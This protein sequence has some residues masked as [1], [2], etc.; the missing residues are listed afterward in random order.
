M[1]LLAIDTSSIACSVA[2]LA[3]DRVAERHAEIPR[4]HTRILLPMIRELLAEEKLTPAMLDAVVLGNGPGSFIGMRIAASVVQGLAYGAGLSVV[5]VSSLCAVAAEVFAHSEAEEV[6]VAQDAH[7]SE[8]YLGIFGRGPDG[9]PRTLVAEHLHGQGTIADLAD[10]GR[11]AR[12]AAGYG[13]TRYPALWQS[14]RGAIREL[15]DVVHPRA[16]YLLALGQM[17]LENGQAIDPKDINPA[18]LRQEVA[19]KSAPQS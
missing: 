18:Y 8:V 10:A 12:I 4:E 15:S 5:P 14:N 6:I 3:G 17:A 7:M 1:K 9:V 11:A 13:W 19:R 16:S 2:L